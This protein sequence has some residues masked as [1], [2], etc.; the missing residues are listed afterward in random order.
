[1]SAERRAD[2]FCRTLGDGLLASVP[3]S[4]IQ[5]AFAQ[6]YPAAPPPDTA[7]FIRHRLD[8]LQCEVTVFFSPRL[9]ELARQC[10]AHRCYPPHAAE[11]ELLL[12]SAAA[13]G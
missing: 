8:G 6:L 2:W 12:G 1:M 7:V 13:L 11:V 3:L 10:G 5:H 4:H 9:A